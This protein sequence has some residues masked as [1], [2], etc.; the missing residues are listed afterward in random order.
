MA[1][2]PHVASKGWYHKS[3][4]YHETSRPLFTLQGANVHT[5]DSCETTQ[6][7]HIMGNM[8]QP[9]PILQTLQGLWGAQRM[10]EYLANVPAPASGIE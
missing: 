10:R 5:C 4:V 9:G 8:H 2:Y 6:P 1:E 7:P 3:H